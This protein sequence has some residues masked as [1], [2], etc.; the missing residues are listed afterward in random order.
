MK[1]KFQ[2]IILIGLL[3]LGLNGQIHAQTPVTFFGTVAPNSQQIVFDSILIGAQQS[4]S[5]ELN[6]MLQP[7]T[8]YSLRITSIYANL[9]TLSTTTPGE[10]DYARI[11]IAE[12]GPGGDVRGFG[13]H[14]ISLSGT[15]TTQ[16]NF[17]PGLYADLRIRGRLGLISLIQSNQ[18]ARVTIHGFLDKKKF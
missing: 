4:T 16:V 2:S 1:T 5:G 10:D 3:A 17:S 7:G 9:F 15:G 12:I 18:D 11:N 13:N 8:D 6:A 14:T